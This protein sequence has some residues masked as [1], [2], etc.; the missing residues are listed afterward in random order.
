MII[1]IAGP[2]SAS[3]E[4]ERQQNLDRLNRAAAQLLEHG[5]VPL[6]GINAALPVLQFATVPDR[7]KAQMDISMAVINACDA[8]LVLAE[9]KGANLERDLILSKNLPVYYSIDEVTL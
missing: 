8:L 7:Y 3:T 1:G 6:V 4:D 5:H 9:S 2:Y